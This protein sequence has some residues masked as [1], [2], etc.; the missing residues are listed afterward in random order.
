MAIKGFGEEYR[1]TLVCV[2]SY[3]NGVISGRF[4]NPYMT[5]EQPFQS[6][7]QFLQGMEATLE[8]MDFPK[9]YTATRT[10]AP[11]PKVTPGDPN[12]QCQ[13]GAQAT[14]AVRILFRQNASW[15]GSVTWLEGKREQ[16]F[17]SVLEL[18]LLMSTALEYPQAS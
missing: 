12:G 1:T 14:F 16:S 15:Q 10:F 5:A 2:D 6:L 18:I 7:T 9:A 3:Q 8:T 13:P 11:L 17:R 4:Y